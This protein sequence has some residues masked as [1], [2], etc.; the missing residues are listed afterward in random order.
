MAATLIV[1]YLYLKG[2]VVSE[3]NFKAFSLIRLLLAFTNSPRRKASARDPSSGATSRQHVG[4]FQETII[5][6]D[7][8][9]WMRRLTAP[10][11]Y[12][13]LDSF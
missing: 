3:G 7:L 9:L 6:F 12:I 8:L 5:N 4:Y 13:L 11:E 1:G 2:P 10:T